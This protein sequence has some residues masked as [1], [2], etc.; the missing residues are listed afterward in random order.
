MNA[1]AVVVGTRMATTTC[2]TE[3]LDG[4]GPANTQER[5]FA[6][7]PPASQGYTVRA[8]DPGTNNITTSVG[9]VNM[10]CMATTGC[11]GVLG[12]SYTAGVVVYFAFESSAGGC[13]AIEVLVD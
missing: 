11:S 3:L 6:F 5:V 2:G 4:C 9:V 10:G 8:F 7:T 13:K 12:T 1:I